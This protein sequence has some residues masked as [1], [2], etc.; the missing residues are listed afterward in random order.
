M[1]KIALLIFPT[2]SEFEVS[3]AI[4]LLRSSHDLVTLSLDNEVVTS[5]AGLRVAPHLEVARA[6]AEDY[7]ALLIP[8]GDMVHLKDAEPVFTFVKRMAEQHRVL[9]AICS[10]PYVLAR[11]GVIS[12]Q[13]YTV[14]LTREQRNFLGCFEEGSYRY[15]PIVETDTI[16][17]AQGHAFVEFGLCVAQTLRPD[18]SAEA[19]RFYSG[20]GNAL[21]ETQP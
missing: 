6:A 14:S 4:S 13:P 1:S 12:N 20:L 2:F 17:T 21:M 10:G 9:A 15:E 7:D 19:R 18:L 11:A 8:G 5:E 16:L 3:V